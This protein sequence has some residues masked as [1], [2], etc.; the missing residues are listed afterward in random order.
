MKIAWVSL[1]QKASSESW[2]LELFLAELCELEAN[3]RYE[4]RLQRLLRDSKLPTGKQLS[5]YDFSQITGV[6]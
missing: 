5:Q 3:D 2:E 6:T 1:A 4:K